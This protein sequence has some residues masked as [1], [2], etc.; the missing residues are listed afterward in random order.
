MN[1]HAKH[2]FT[3]VGLDDWQDAL[4]QVQVEDY[5][6]AQRMDMR[7]VFAWCAK[8]RTPFTRECR[9]SAVC[10]ALDYPVVV[11]YGLGD[12]ENVRGFR[13]GF[14]GPDYMS[15]FWGL[16]DAPDGDLRWNKEKK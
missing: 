4:W 5:P 7:Q 2:E 8:G 1:E 15:G 3:K 6:E 12:N 13:Y 14:D 9:Y 11:F 10:S 16:G